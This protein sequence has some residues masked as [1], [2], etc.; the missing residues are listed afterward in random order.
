MRYANVRRL[1]VWLRGP[2]GLD[3][4]RFRAE[5]AALACGGERLAEKLRRDAYCDS[6]DLS[7]FLYSFLSALAALV[8]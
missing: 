1:E 2:N 3:L 8:V 5:A 7:M 4:E 6:S